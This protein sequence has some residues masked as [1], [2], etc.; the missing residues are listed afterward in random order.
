MIKTK[1]M[2]NK[3][4]HRNWAASTVLTVLLLCSVGM[5]NC[6]AYDF[7]AVC[8]TGQTLYYSITDAENHYVALVCPGP[9]N[10]NECWFGF[11]KPFGAIVLPENVQ[12]E[13]NTY[14][15]TSIGSYAFFGCSSLT[16]SLTIPNSVIEI[17]S[18]AFGN[19][20]GFTGS[21]TIPNSVT[22]IGDYVFINCFG[23]TGSLTIGNS[24]TMIGYQ[25]FRDCSGFTGSLTIPNSVTMIG[26]GAF[27]GC[28]GFTG[29]LTIG[30]SVMTIGNSAFYDCSGFTGSLTIGNSVS[31]IGHRAFRDCSGFTGS[32]TI[33]NSVTTIGGHAFEGCSGFTGDLTISDSVTIIGSDTFYNCSGFTGSLTIPNSVA[34]IGIGAFSFCSGFTG[35]LT[36]GNSVSTIGTNAFW[37]CQGF[38]GSLTIGNSVSEIGHRA[39][40]DCSGFTGS[41]TIPNSV[42]MIGDEAFLGCQGFTGSLTIGNSVIEICSGAFGNC[43]G[44]TGNL[45]IPNSVT[46]IGAGAFFGC[47]GFTGSLTIGNSVIEICS[48]AFGN[49]SGFTGSLT[50]PNSV[51]MIGDE[52]FYG[53]TGFTGSLTIGNSVMTIGNSAFY[54]CSGFT[55]NLTIG[56]SVIEIGSSAFSSCNGFTGNLTIPNSVTMIDDF[57]FSGCQGFTGRLTIGNSVTEIG[58]AAFYYCSSFDSIVVELGNAVYDSRENC[59]ALI[60]TSTNELLFGCKNTIIPNSVIMIGD[61]AFYN[62]SGFTG[63]LTIPN[64]VTTIGGSAFWNCSGLTGSL[65]IPNSVTTIGF[66][67]FYGCNGLN[68]IMILGTTPPSLRSSAFNSTNN[69]PIYV[70]YESLNDYKTATNWSSYQNRILPWL[71]KDVEGYGEDAGNWRFIAS[72]CVANTAPTA[73]DNMITETAYDLYR[74]DQSEDAEWQN[75]K[76]SENTPNFFLTN[77]QGYLYANAEDVNLIFKGEF[78]EDDTKEVGLAYDANAELA[79]WNLVGNPFPVNAY[80]NKSYYTM[81]EDGSA[82]EPVAVSMETAIPPCTG[83]MVRAEMTEQ[84]VTF[85]KESRQVSNNNGTLQIAV[86]QNNTRSNAI[87]DKAIV[88]FNEGDELGKFVFNKDNAKLYIPQ[89]NADYAIAYAEKQGEMPLSFEAKESGSYTISVNPKGVEMNYLHLIDNMT[90]TDVDLLVTPSYTFESK[91]S[92]YASRFRLMFSAGGDT[93]DEN[94]EPFAFVS[95]G[96]IIVTGEYA[97]ATLQIVDML[98]HVVVNTDVAHNVSTNG[99]ASGVYVLRLINGNDVKTQKIVVR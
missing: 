60:K 65:T 76:F 94:E 40:R 83:I 68:E 53:C 84:S 2:K 49:C 66:G 19:C 48:G 22:T 5:T 7:S 11:T 54:D 4:L 35:D 73:V 51:T 45:T 43:S 31:E 38:T 52:T 46:T 71:Q 25:A 56:N 9:T 81:N 93:N 55:G 12:Y 10:P 21:L 17:C 13:G 26:D 62:C 91:T 63:D 44:F 20:S 92:D 34:E 39:F 47:S 69:C 79:G 75:Y 89:G 18:G 72:P 58:D 8:E 96:N 16:G 61:E 95:N 50:I 1:N 97:N 98:G 15:V 3:I 27:Y 70:P 23:F 85:T 64:S 6:Y 24:V 88:S 87:Q 77:G 82:I 74:F 67:A 99:I 14:A 30:N 57:A 36:I 59:N 86:A 28:T 32:L 78:N 29:S 33:P 42:T 41:L 80:A 90:G 37:G